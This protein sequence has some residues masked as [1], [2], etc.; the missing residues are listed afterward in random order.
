MRISQIIRALPIA[1][2]FL[3]LPLAHGAGRGAVKS[4]YEIAR[5][6]KGSGAFENPTAMNRTLEDLNC[7]AAANIPEDAALELTRTHWN[8]ALQRW[9]FVLRCARRAD[10]V[11]FL[12]W[13]HAEKSDAQVAHSQFQRP[14]LV[15]SGANIAADLVKSG[16]TALLTW[17]S[18]GIR[19]VLPVTCLDAGSLGQTVRVRFQHVDRIVRAEVVGA[20]ALTSTL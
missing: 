7:A 16:Q 20:G 6:I 15:G 18:A 8:A 14:D 3:A 11:P 2:C 17:D 5:H 9:E 13:A 12:V 4:C 19:V 1:G 10:C